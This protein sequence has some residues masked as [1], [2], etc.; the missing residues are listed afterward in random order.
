VGAGVAA[1]ELE[2]GRGIRGEEGFGEVRGKVDV[3][4]IAVAGRILYGDEAD[5]TC[6][7][8]LENAVSL[9]ECGKR[10]EE[11]GTGEAHGDF[12][13]GEIAETKEEILDCVC[14][15]GALIFSE[16]LEAGFDLGDCGGVEKL[17]EVGFTKQ[18]G[19]LGLIDGE[20][21][22]AALGEGRIAVIDEVAGVSE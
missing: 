1:N 11:L 19:E 20:G 7:F 15:V 17:A 22:G 3:E 13:A 21:C 18:I 8:D 2:D 4:G 10:L 16:K 6:D 5:L 14:G 9:R 12:V